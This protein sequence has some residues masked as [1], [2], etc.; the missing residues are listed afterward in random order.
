VHF[1]VSKLKENIVLC[2]YAPNRGVR[3]V[4][5]GR[6]VMKARASDRGFSDGEKISFSAGAT[7][8]LSDSQ[9][10]ALKN[11]RQF[12][13]YIASG[14]FILDKD[15][16]A[17]ALPPEPVPEFEL[18]AIPDVPVKLYDATD[19]HMTLKKAAAEVMGTKTEDVKTKQEA[20]TILQE[21]DLWRYEDDQ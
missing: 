21:A 3:T 13:A 5:E 14:D 18:A 1:I 6:V 4:R 19:N 8:P 16:L 10:E 15:D 12:Q 20:T 9:F 11:H 7:T 17:A 2:V